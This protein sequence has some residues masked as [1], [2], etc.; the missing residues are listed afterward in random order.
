MTIEGKKIPCSPIKMVLGLRWKRFSNNFKNFTKE[1]L[2]NLMK[3]IFEEI[4]KTTERVLNITLLPNS[5][6]CCHAFNPSWY[7]YPVLQLHPPKGLDLLEYSTST[8]VSISL[9]SSK[10]PLLMHDSIFVS[11]LHEFPSSIPFFLTSLIIIFIW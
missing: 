4:F 8:W 5:L 7:I 2:V 6:L 11:H 3:N 1:I 10:I 9:Y